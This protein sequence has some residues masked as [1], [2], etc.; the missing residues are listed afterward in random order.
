MTFEEVDILA[1]DLISC[2]LVIFRQ[3]SEHLVMLGSF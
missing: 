1:R 3:A 2:R